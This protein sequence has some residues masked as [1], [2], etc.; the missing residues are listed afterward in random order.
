ML[1]NFF[2]LSLMLTIN[3]LGRLLLA[4]FYPNPFLQKIAEAEKALRNKRSSLFVFFIGDE[5]KGFV[6]LTLCIYVTKLFS[7][8]TDADNK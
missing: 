2:S 4:C 7:F 3:K 6:T 5:E 1:Q 8:V